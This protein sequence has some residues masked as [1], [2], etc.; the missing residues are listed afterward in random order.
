[1]EVIK[2]GAGEAKSRPGEKDQQRKRIEQMEK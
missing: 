2:G 1:M